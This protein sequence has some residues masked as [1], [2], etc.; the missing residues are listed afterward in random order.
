MIG[1]VWVDMGSVM[2]LIAAGS[3]ARTVPGDVGSCVLWL[4]LC[5]GILLSVQFV[6]KLRA[7][8]SF[9]TQSMLHFFGD[10]QGSAMEFRLMEKGLVEQKAMDGVRM[11]GTE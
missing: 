1:G 2:C 3:I 6:F 4:Q 11:S 5:P 7:M 8:K 9:L 10:L